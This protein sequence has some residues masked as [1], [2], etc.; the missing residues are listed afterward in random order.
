MKIGLSLSRC[1]RDI[2]NGDVDINDILVIVSR[3]DFDPENDTHWQGIWQ[4]YHIGGAWNHPEWAEVS[5][6][7]KLRQICVDLKNTGR[8]HQPRQFGHRPRRLPYYWMEAIPAEEEMTTNPAVRDAWQQF[9]TVAGLTGTK[10]SH[11]QEDLL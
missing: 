1:V 7:Q 5:D 6:E 3:T 9:K 2:Y 11:D 8:L 4:G 10:I